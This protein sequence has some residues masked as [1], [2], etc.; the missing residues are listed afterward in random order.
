MYLG[1]QPIL[2]LRKSYVRSN[3]WFI[4]YSIYV[5]AY[6]IRPV[7]HRMNR[8]AQTPQTNATTSQKS[9]NSGI[10]NTPLQ[11]RNTQINRIL[12]THSFF[13]ANGT[14]HH[15]APSHS[16]HLIV[17]V[18]NYVV[19]NTLYVHGITPHYFHLQ[20]ISAGPVRRLHVLP[21]A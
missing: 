5:G 11:Q 12:T 4:A 15:S 7:C 1:K 16:I 8:I 20:L 17:Y 14:R 9:R 19:E 21:S 2:V 13:T 3:V 6:G 10:C 18:R